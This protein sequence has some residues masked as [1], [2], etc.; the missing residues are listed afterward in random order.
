MERMA[1]WTKIASD[2]AEPEGCGGPT[3]EGENEV[4]RDFR[5][6]P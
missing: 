6:N 4:W 2:E 3:V 1:L 5:H